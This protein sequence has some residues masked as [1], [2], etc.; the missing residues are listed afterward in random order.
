MICWTSHL[1][2]GPDQGRWTA[3]AVIDEVYSFGGRAIDIDGQLDVHVFNT[4][5]LRWRKLTP[6]A[7]GRTGRHLEVP[8]NRWGYTPV[9]IEDTIY[10]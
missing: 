9:L 5:S 4:V 10:I 2:R 3:V 7:P 6:E 8:F 1:N